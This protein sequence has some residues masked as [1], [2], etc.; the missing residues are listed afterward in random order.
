MSEQE[1]KQSKG[2]FGITTETKDT[3]NAPL[4]VATRV[5]NNP[6]FPSGWKFPIAYLVNIVSNNEYEKKDG[7]KVAILQFI[8]RDKDN[9]Q[10]IHTEWEIDGGDTKFKEKKD[11]L[12][13][14]I[15]H[16]YTSIFVQFPKEGFGTEATTWGEFFDAVKKAFDKTTGE[17]DDKKLYYPTVAL[18]YKLTYY[19]AR[20]NFPLSPNF[21]ERVV[22]DKAMKLLTI[23]TVWDKLVP[24]TG[25]GGGGI[26]GIGSGNAS[27]DLPTFEKE[28]S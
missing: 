2:M 24:T 28:Y 18:F 9:R 11:G 17:G 27:D 25:G 10:H 21:L 3:N 16:I 26:P 8:F 5:E 20:M 19:K 22:K 4:L 23:N 7:A 15:K 6:Q 12:D 14:R 13:S 1:N